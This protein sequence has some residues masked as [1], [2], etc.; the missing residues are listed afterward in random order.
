MMMYF[1][2]HIGCDIFNVYINLIMYFISHIE[3]MNH[4]YG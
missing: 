1:I 3:L 2:S 4:A